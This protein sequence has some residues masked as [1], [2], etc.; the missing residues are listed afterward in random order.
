MT[1]IEKNFTEIRARIAAAAR[2]VDRDAGEISLVAVSKTKPLSA[3]LAAHAA[4][5][6]IFGENYLQ[7]A[8]DKIENCPEKLCWHFI[9]HLQSNKARQV[10]ELFDMVET[11]DRLKLAKA[12]DKYA[13]EFQRR[14]DVL[15]QVNI[16]REARKS[17]VLPEDASGLLAGIRS[18]PNLSLKGIMIMPP[19][20]PDPENSRSY[21]RKAG[22]LAADLRAKGLFGNLKSVELSMGMSGDFEV[23][24]E[25]GATIVRVGTALFGERKSSQG[26]SGVAANSEQ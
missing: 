24:I 16:G 13:G 17:G 8:R 3:V 18:L 7:D 23:A 26:K 21:F 6:N 2:R 5:Q 25:E 12:L 9:G 1:D 20:S 22:K 11:V 4:G 19:Y 10:A 15:A 14:L